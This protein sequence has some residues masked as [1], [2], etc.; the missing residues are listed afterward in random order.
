MYFRSYRYL[1]KLLNLFN[2]IGI[3]N[4][5]W[6][7]DD[8]HLVTTSTP[9]LLPEYHKILSSWK[10]NY[11]DLGFELQH[12]CPYGR[13]IATILLHP[14]WPTM[15][16]QCWTNGCQIGLVLYQGRPNE[17]YYMVLTRGLEI[18]LL[19]TPGLVATGLSVGCETW[20]PTGW[21]HPFGIG[22]VV[23]I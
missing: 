20:P 12:S 19:H 22:S 10:V 9:I 5:L 15:L 16:D 18:R 23:Q 8:R 7:M 14:I 13:L 2:F 11:K 1:E 17:T 6:H 3:I 21:N 4:Y